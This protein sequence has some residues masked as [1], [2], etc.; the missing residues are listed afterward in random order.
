MIVISTTSI[1]IEEMVK[2]GIPGGF[3]GGVMSPWY[4]E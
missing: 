4:G 3:I 2:T 1:V